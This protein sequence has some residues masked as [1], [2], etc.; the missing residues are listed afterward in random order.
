MADGYAG[1]FVKVG[2][3]LAFLALVACATPPD[4]AQANC[5]AV[6]CA[7]CPEG[8]TPALVPPECCKCV[9]VDTQITDCARVRCASC[10][11][12]QTP[13]LQPPDCCTCVASQ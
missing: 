7:G 3:L 2:V 5:D 4:A 10:P 13:K 11:P 8:Q 6:R 12:G 9:S 1:R